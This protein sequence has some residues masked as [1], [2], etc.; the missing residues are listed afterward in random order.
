M[1]SEEN[2]EGRATHQKIGL[3]L[4]PAVALIM[5]LSN[6]PEGL[7]EAGWAT[8]ACGILMAIWWATEAVPIAVTALL[9][10][11]AFPLLGITTIQDTAAPYANKV[12]FLFLGGFIVAYTMQ[13]WNLHRRI[14]LN[15]LQKFGSNGKSLV[16][17]FMFASAVISMW[18]MNTSTTMMLLPIAVSIITVIHKSVHT[19]DQKAR[20]DFQYA[21]LL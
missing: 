13:R 12:I 21:L 14:A 17:G 11:V 7:S 19:L 16:A 8:A 6:A 5:L 1:T 2:I 18:V 4:G 10:L 20:D 9:P 3:F 15:V